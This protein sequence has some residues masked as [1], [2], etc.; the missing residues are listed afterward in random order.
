[1]DAAR[2][3]QLQAIFL[4]TADLPAVARRAALNDACGEDEDL[5]TAVLELL[6]ADARTGG[7][8]DGDLAEVAGDILDSPWSLSP[9]SERFGPYRIVE[10]IKEGGMGVV[11][12]AERTDVGQRVA[13]KVLRDAWV[14]PSRRARFAIEQRTLARLSHPSI[15]RLYDVDTLDEGTPFFVMEYVD[16]VPIT[17][18]CRAGGC[19]IAARL[20]LLR[21][22]C[23]AVQHAHRQLIVHRDLKPSNVLVTADGLV[24]LLDFGISK[25]I[26]ALTGS[27][28]QTQIYRMLTPR[29]AAPEQH[30]GEEVG[31]YTDIYALGVMLYELLAGSLPPEN[32]AVPAGERSLPPVAPP[33]PSVIGST[34]PWGQSL[35]K[36]AWA[37]LDVLCATAMHHDIGR[38][39]PTVDA[40]IRDID[41]YTNRQPL[42]ARPDGWRYRAGKFVTRHA[43]AVAATFAVAAMIGGLVGF[44]TFRLAS[45]RNAAVAEA[46]R[47]QRIQQF[48]LSLFDAGDP[49]VAPASEMKVLTLVDRGVQEARALD[50]DPAIQAALFQTLGTVYQGL[51]EFD[52]ADGLLRQAVDQQGRLRDGDRGDVADSLVSLGLSKLAQAKFSEAER[53]INEGLQIGTR[54]LPR[55]HP[56]IARATAALGKTI[57]AQGAYARAIPILESA[58]QLYS[59][60]GQAPL[61][62]SAAI[63]ELANTHFYAGHLDQAEA[64]NRQVLEM[65]RRLRGSGHPHVADDLLNLAAIESSRGR[66][67]DAEQLDRDAVAILTAWYGADHPETASAMTI[68][69]Q[70][71][72]FQRRQLDE[73]AALLQ[74]ALAT[75]ER[76]YGPSHPRVGFVLNESGNV[77]M[78]RQAFDEAEA[79]F[80]RSLAVNRAAYPDGRHFR[81]GVALSNLGG[82]V[83]G[84]GDYARAEP[85]LREAVTVLTAAQSAQHV[86][87]ANAHV[88][89]GRTL[90]HL[91]RPGDAEPELLAG[92]GVLAAKP[93]ASATWLRAAREDLA[94]VYEALGRPVEARRYRD[95]LAAAATPQGR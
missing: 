78:Q 6:E 77:A 34:Q 74:R 56:T 60:G 39:Y 14:S 85:L 22:V 81:I 89:L 16:G 33:A 62:I 11:Y 25:E 18:H 47:T 28:D 76:V 26:D 61:E 4:R 43:T 36:S 64:L 80:T 63:T 58:V 84:R 13:I 1:M 93:S 53:L 8:V 29:Y 9:A 68:L 65:D 46:A 38:R 48:M 21:G 20:A 7:A 51:A 40:L 69:A 94:A 91:G 15:A 71:L 92:Y 59:A 41:H 86:N 83:M 35:A 10:M 49:E 24:K 57:E 70:A 31:V 72:T 67:G 88:K 44:Y 75:Q 73:A 42:D 19:S 2:W 95:E 12:L 37:D 87:T 17:E 50:R 27:V 5:K 52:R 54:S 45:A 30:R 32:A 66:H 55:N 90:L 3:E 23:V 82:A 79:A